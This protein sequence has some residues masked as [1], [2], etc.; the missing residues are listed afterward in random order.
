MSIFKHTY[1]GLIT[2][3]LGN[4]ACCGLITMQFHVFKCKIEIITPP[5][6]GGGGGS[7][8]LAPGQIQNFYKPVQPDKFYVPRKPQYQTIIVRITMDG[9]VTTREYKTFPVVAKAIAKIINITTLAYE[10]IKVRA[11]NLRNKFGAVVASIKRIGNKREFIN[12]TVTD[13]K[14]KE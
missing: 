5:S 7:Y 1:S 3:G 10:S 4:P 12:P 11:N 13:V 2:G 14:N 8:P 9:K 6:G